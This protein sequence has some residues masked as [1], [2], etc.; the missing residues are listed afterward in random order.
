MKY[1]LFLCYFGKKYDLLTFLLRIQ[2]TN[3]CKN[4]LLDIQFVS[5]G[6]IE[7]LR[8]ATRLAVPILSPNV[9]INELSNSNKKQEQFNVLNLLYYDR[10]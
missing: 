3:F 2:N 9:A 7:V 10:A 1:I 5:C 6:L 8:K 4:S